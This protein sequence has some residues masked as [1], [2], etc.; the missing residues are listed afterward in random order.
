MFAGLSLASLALKFGVSQRTLKFGLIAA[1]IVALVIGVGV[2]K[3][4]YDNSVIEHHEAGQ[5]A[6][7]AKADRKADTRSAE[8][9]RADD[10]RLTQETQQLERAQANAKTDLDRRLARHRCLRQQQAARSSGSKP[11]ACN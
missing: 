8:Q 4:A 3:C 9:R 10:S 6:S 2:A 11:P 1:A 7:N 5:T